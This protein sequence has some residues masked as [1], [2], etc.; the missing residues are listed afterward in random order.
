MRNDLVS[1]FKVSP[2]RCK[3]CGKLYVALYQ[4]YSMYAEF[5]DGYDH[6]GRTRAAIRGFI[7][8]LV[9]YEQGQQN[10]ENPEPTTSEPLTQNPE[11]TTL[12]SR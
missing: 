9:S 3:H 12:Y 11:P 8:Y 5:Q 6:A 2:Q 10:K 1:Q 4:Q 7:K